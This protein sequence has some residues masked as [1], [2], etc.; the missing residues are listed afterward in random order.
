MVPRVWRDGHEIDFSTWESNKIVRGE[1]IVAQEWSGGELSAK[2][3]GKGMT[4]RADDRSADMSW[5]SIGETGM[6]DTPMPI[7]T[8]GLLPFPNPFDTSTVKSQ[9]RSKSIF[10]IRMDSLYGHYFM[11]ICLP[12]STD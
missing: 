6:Q 3:S 5:N 12:D 10:G 1:P 2:V 7:K 4:I 11:D 8:R 9:V